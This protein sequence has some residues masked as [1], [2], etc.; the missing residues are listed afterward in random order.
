IDCWRAYPEG[1]KALYEEAKLDV[2]MSTWESLESPHYSRYIPGQSRE[3]QKGFARDIYQVLGKLGFP[4]ER[5][6]DTITIGKANRL[7]NNN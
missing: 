3:S 2:I 6:Y 4:F 5:A 7:L 1:M